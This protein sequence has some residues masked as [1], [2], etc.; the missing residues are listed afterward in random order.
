MNLAGVVRRPD[1]FAEFVRCAWPYVDASTLKWNWHHTVICE[2]FESDDS[3]AISVPP[4][5]SKSLLA[6]LWNAWVWTVDPAHAFLVASYSDD[7]LERDAR[8]VQ[9]LVQS[10][11]YRR[12]WPSVQLAEGPIE[13]LRTTAG[14]MRFSTTPRGTVTGEHFDTQILD[15]LSKAGPM[16]TAA[17]LEVV[18]KFLVEALPTRWRNPA[19]GR[20]ITIAQRLAMD[21]AISLAISDGARE[22]RL[23]MRAEIPLC[24]GDTRQEGE[25][26]WPDRYPEDV[27]RRLEI[28]LGPRQAAAQLQQRPV[29]LQGNL[30]KADT[31]QRYTTADDV[32]FDLIVVTADLAFDGKSTSDFTVIQK[33]GR[34]AAGTFF[35]LEERR[36]QW[37]F[38]RAKY[39]LTRIAQE[40][41]ESVKVYIER[42]ANG[43]ATL[44]VLEREFPGRLEGVP[45]VG[46][47]TNRLAAVAPLFDNKRVFVPSWYDVT[48]WTNFPSAKYDDRVDTMSM[49]LAILSDDTETGKKAK[50]LRAYDNWSNEGIRT[51]LL[52]LAAAA[53]GV[54]IPTS[55]QSWRAGLRG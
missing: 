1:A 40:C 32:E 3:L 13:L 50:V 29:P 53:N 16:L 26:L 39:E 21:D 4:G 54:Q 23:P 46:S 30:I 41:E 55:Y 17:E 33:W 37:D 19:N 8:R 51:A 43:A 35:L 7:L 36:G 28:T 47:K 14:G 49:A 45:P 11:W 52:G 24:Q 27:V 48:E 20:R 10:P 34:A 22:I 38:N 44:A 2:A 9:R 5:C 18:R 31:I 12:R 6:T 15:D 25:L 42:A